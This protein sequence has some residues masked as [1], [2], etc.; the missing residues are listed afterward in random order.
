M[1]PVY[2]I[3]YYNTKNGNLLGYLDKSYNT[4]TKRVDRL[5][6]VGNLELVETV[7]N[8]SLNTFF[9]WASGEPFEYYQELLEGC[10]KEEVE[11]RPDKH[12]LVMRK[13]KLNK[14]KKNERKN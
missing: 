2:V 1:K 8:A 5:V 4:I 13:Y 6:I 12:S 10:S 7:G 3:S 9:I 11:I 14:I